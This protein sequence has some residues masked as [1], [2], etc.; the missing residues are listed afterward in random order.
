[1]TI[2]DTALRKLEELHVPR[3]GLWIIKRKQFSHLWNDQ[4]Y[5]L[6]VVDHYLKA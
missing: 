1:M 5:P 2:E 4:S 6:T 3:S